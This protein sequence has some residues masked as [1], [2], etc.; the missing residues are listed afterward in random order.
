M[1]MLVCSPERAKE[2]VEGFWDSMPALKALKA[3][4]EAHWEANDKKFVV[5]IDGRKINIRSKHSI[6]N[7]LFQSAGVISAKY[8]NVL[9]MQKLEELG[10]CINPFEGVPDVCEM[11]A[12]HDECQL[13]CG[14]SLFDFPVFETED[15]AKAFVADF[16]STEGQLSAISEGKKWYVCQP[17]VVSKSIEEAIEDTERILKL[18][19][20]LGY[21]WIVNTTWYGCH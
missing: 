4:V 18:N 16:D 13:F 14:K 9:S 19:V 7:A 11:I 12:Y 2:I 8:V 17:N 6:L 3:N 15:E 10:Y 20:E 5:G 21:E 1:K